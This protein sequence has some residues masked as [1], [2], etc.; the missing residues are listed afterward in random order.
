MLYGA[1]KQHTLARYIPATSPPSPPGASA[2]YV[3]THPDITP[4]LATT[5]REVHSIPRQRHPPEKDHS[6]THS[7]K[8]QYSCRRCKLSRATPRTRR[9]QSCIS[10]IRFRICIYNPHPNPHPRPHPQCNKR[11][12]GH[13]SCA[14]HARARRP[15]KRPG[16]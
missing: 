3:C 8:I 11:E 4:I 7:L 6:S 16:Q 14:H 2:T 9:C 13:T 10:L 15:E 12:A 1:G 5:A